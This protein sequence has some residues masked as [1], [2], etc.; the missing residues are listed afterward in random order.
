MPHFLLLFLVVFITFICYGIYIPLDNHKFTMVLEFILDISGP[1]PPTLLR[2]DSQCFHDVST[3][4]RHS[5]F[6]VCKI[7]NLKK[8]LHCIFRSANSFFFIKSQ[9]ICN[10]CSLFPI[11]LASCELFQMQFL[12]ILP[13]SPSILSFY[14]LYL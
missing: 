4:L 11:V 9:V 2:K 6:L 1:I 14:F 7:L 8:V 5:A 3:S 10:F 13:F 12:F